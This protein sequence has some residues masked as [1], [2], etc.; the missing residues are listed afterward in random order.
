M[1]RSPFKKL[2]QVWIISF[3]L[4]STACSPLSAT[5][6]A[7]ISRK[8]AIPTISE[9]QA[10]AKQKEDD[11]VGL[12]CVLLFGFLVFSHMTE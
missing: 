2:L 7:R 4:L 6:G 8:E 10:K 12:A 5:R 9:L 1:T 11:K 3:F